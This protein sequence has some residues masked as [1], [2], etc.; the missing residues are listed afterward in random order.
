MAEVYK[1][2]S[3]K[4]AW[5]LGYRDL[6]E[7]HIKELEKLD[8]QLLEGKKVRR[9]WLWSRGHFKTSLL[10]ELHIIQLILNNPN[11]RI[12]IVS[13]TLDIAKTMLKNVRNQFISNDDFRFFFKEYCP[14]ASKDGKIEFGTTENF[15]IPNRTKNY[16]E[17][18]V[19]CAGIG[20]NLTGLHFD[21]MKI[22][23]LVTKDSVTNEEQI[24]ASKECYSSLRQLFDNPLVPREDVIGT[25]YHFNDLYQDIIK[26]DDFEKSIIPARNEDGTINFK[27]RFN[28][29]GLESLL[30]DPTVG[31]YSFNSQYMLNPINPKDAKFKGE[32][33]KYY[34]TLT[35]GMAEYI[36]CDPASTQ[37]KKSDYTVIE[38][39]GIDHEGKHH[40]LDGVRDKLTA[41]QRIDRLFEMVEHARNLKLVKYEVQG[42]RHGDIEVINQRMRESGK[43]FVVKEITSTVASKR[44]RIEQRLVGPYYSGSILL[45]RTLPY[46]SIYDGKVHD[47]VK[48]L[49]VELLQFPYTIHDDILDCQSQMFEDAVL[50]GDN[51]APIN[52]I[53]G[54]TADMEEAQYKKIQRIMN[55]N[56]FGD[57]QWAKKRFNAKILRRVLSR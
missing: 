47:F 53:N 34:D 4:L 28:D 52:R 17:H 55:N 11:I 36:C 5:L 50:R 12:L 48:D 57:Y 21:W 33:I 39:W 41:F 19:T 18:T 26:F 32:W 54:V 43:F 45:P 42:G 23:D 29:E 7:F 49:I 40:L 44:D 46:K 2:S 1:R 14:K 31:P 37:K 25:T 10:T 9:L 56:P 22:D 24:K 38:R 16:K 13:N 35:E 27:E 51:V 30:N 3:L 20:T 6:G 15:T 8:T